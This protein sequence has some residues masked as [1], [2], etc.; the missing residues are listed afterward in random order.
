MPG[1]LVYIRKVTIPQSALPR[2]QPPLHKGAFT[3]RPQIGSYPV[4]ADGEHR[5]LQMRHR[6]GRG[7]QCA[8]VE[9]CGSAGLRGRTMFAPTAHVWL[10]VGG[11]RPRRP[12]LAP[13]GPDGEGRKSVKKRAALLHVLAFPS[14]DPRFGVPRGEQP[15]GR[16]SLPRNSETFFVSFFGHKKGKFPGRIPL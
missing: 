4:R 12:V 11:R 5:P 14:L 3:L 9:F 2:S 7:A 13:E 16:G 10:A 6:S 1:R 15:L 8:P